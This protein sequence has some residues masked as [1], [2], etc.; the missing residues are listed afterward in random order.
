MK[1]HSDIA[2]LTD[3]QRKY[4]FG[5]DI[6][7]SIIISP[8]DKNAKEAGLALVEKIKQKTE[9]EDV[10][11]IGSLMLEISGSNDI[12]VMCFCKKEIL[13]KISNYYQKR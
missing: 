5:I 4:L 10:Y 7:K 8:F 12:D 6:A 13:S 1:L 3:D 9:L 2:D 11:L